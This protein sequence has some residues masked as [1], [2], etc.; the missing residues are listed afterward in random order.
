MRAYK[1]AV[2]EREETKAVRLVYGQRQSWRRW[3]ISRKIL[4][5][6]DRAD[7]DAR[8]VK[9]RRRFQI[10]SFGLNCDAYE[11]GFEE[12]LGMSEEVRVHSRRAHT[13]RSHA[14]HA[15]THARHARNLPNHVAS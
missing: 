13:P 1:R 3:T 8:T 15:G 12:A 11:E 6:E 5:K 2:H 7:R 4:G 14:T 10:I 9:Q